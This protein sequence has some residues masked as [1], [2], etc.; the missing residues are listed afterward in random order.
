MPNTFDFDRSVRETGNV[1]V[2]TPGAVVAPPGVVVT[3]LGV[4]VATP[5]V[6]WPGIRT[7]ESLRQMRP[8]VALKAT[9]ELHAP[10]PFLFFARARTW[11]LIDFK[12]LNLQLFTRLA[13]VQDNVP[14]F[15]CVES[16]GAARFVEARLNW[17]VTSTFP[18][19][20]FAE[21]TVIEGFDG[22]ALTD[23]ALAFVAPITAETATKSG[24]QIFPGVLSCIMLFLSTITICS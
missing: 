23:R 6:V 15:T 19:R 4:V 16:I 12:F 2:V 3:T 18:E 24:I 10:Q 13:T 1:V 9:E 11:Y 8:S 20:T 5:G 17:T 7:F 22:L 21:I 14:T